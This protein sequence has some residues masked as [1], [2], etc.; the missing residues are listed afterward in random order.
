MIVGIGVDIVHIPR[1]TALIAR[2]GQ[3]KL[4]Q[5]ILSPLELK[6][7]KSQSIQS[8]SQSSYLCSR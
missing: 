4:A 5:R 7:F 2:R 6:E 8:S 1:I 3:Q